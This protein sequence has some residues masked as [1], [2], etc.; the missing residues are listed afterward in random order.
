M[1]IGFIG[2]G[3]MGSGMAENLIRAGHELILYNRSREK[4]EA[5]SKLGASITDSIA[6]ACRGEVV[7]TM[8]ADDKALEDVGLGESGLLASLAPEALHVSSSTI[9]VALCDRLTQAHADRRQRFVAAPV[10]GRPDAAK[11]GG[12]F[13]VAGGAPDAIHLANPLFDVI[14][15][16]TFVVCETPKAANLVK[17]SG[18]FLIAS[19]I[20]LLGEAMALVGKG[21]V[22]KHQYLEILTSTLFD[23]PVYKTYGAL[24]AGANLRTG[25]FRRAARSQGPAARACRRGG[26]P[27]AAAD[28]KPSARPLPYATRERRRGARLV[29]DRCCRRL[30]SWRRQIRGTW[31][32]ES[33]GAAF[34][35]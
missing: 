17:L 9:S 34:S 11:A 13:V 22:D 20:E 19:V 14:G 8:L 6:E 10:F 33:P 1:K 4:A 16:R 32:A 23:A 12:L 28:R 25:G 29:G 26:S 18:N 35:G 15:Q 21:G 5:L 2:I 24:I 31:R 30:G 27:R 3:R 7:W